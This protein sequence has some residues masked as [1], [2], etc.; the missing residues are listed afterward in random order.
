MMTPQEF[1]NIV[2]Q[3]N[4]TDETK[5]LKLII[6]DT[7][8]EN[9]TLYTVIQVSDI[10]GLPSQQVNQLYNLIDMLNGNTAN[11]KSTPYEFS[12]IILNNTD[13]EQIKAKLTLVNQVM[14]STINNTAYTYSELAKLINS[15]ESKLKSVYMLY[16]TENK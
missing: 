12:N 4:A 8:T 16:T 5:L 6:D 10:L 11:W 3:N 13:D 15:E 7:C 14:T 2:V 9:K 1:I